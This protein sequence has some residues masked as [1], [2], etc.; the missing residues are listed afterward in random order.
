MDYAWYM[1]GMIDFERTPY[2]IERCFG[3]DMA[4]AAADRRC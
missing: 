1:K 4:Q 2:A 3:V